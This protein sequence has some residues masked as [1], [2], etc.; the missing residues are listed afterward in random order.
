MPEL[1]SKLSPRSEDFK[2]NAAAMRS[3]VDDLNK[4]L[5]DTAEANRT[6]RLTFTS[7]PTIAGQV[8]ET[9]RELFAGKRIYLAGR[10]TFTRSKDISTSHPFLLIEHLGNP[11]LVYFVP[12]NGDDWAC[13]EAATVSFAAGTKPDNDLLFLTAFEGAKALPSG[14]FRRGY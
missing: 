4:R 9:Y 2:T 14:G 10:M 5:G 12:R 8:S 11:M 13:E 3:L 7:D 6:V 1:A